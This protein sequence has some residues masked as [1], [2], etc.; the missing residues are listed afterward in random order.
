MNLAVNAG[1]DAS[2][3]HSLLT[4]LSPAHP[5]WSRWIADDESERTYQFFSEGSSTFTTARS[6]CGNLGATTPAARG[7]IGAGAATASSLTIVYVGYAQ[8]VRTIT[9]PAGATGFYLGSFG[10]MGSF[11]GN[12]TLRIA[13]G[14]TISLVV[15]DDQSLAPSISSS[16][17]L[18]WTADVIAA[19]RMAV[20]VI[21]ASNAPKRLEDDAIEIA[22]AATAAAVPLPVPKLTGDGEI[23]FYGRK[24]D[25][26]LDLGVHGDGT[27]S[28]FC[29]DA[30]GNE[31]VSDDDKHVG[32]GLDENVSRVLR[33]IA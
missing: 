7:L 5:P 17:E 10:Y 1:R 11:G 2:P 12:G 6:I 31:F 9:G 8:S 26:Y 4:R 32:T 27:Y 24:N 25:A 33:D 28:F 14:P 18:Q 22:R 23:M 16:P 3:L 19:N 29:R 21:R 15:A 13:E 20:E 30:E